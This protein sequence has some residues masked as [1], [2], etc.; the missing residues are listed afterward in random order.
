VNA[1]EGG[2]E[3]SLPICPSKKQWTRLVATEDIDDPFAMKGV[4]DKVI[5]GGR[6][7]MLFTDKDSPS[8]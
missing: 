7:L 8:S 6:S 1:A 3:F 4:D 2:V 5:V